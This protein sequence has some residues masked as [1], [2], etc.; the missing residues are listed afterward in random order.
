MEAMNFRFLRIQLWWTH[1]DSNQGPPACEAD[2]KGMAIK[3]LEEI[4]RVFGAA[5]HS[6]PHQIR[7]GLARM[8]ATI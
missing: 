8:L 5:R 1:L 7:S 6:Y 4:Q 2:R 3:G